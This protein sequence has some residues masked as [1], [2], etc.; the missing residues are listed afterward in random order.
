MS[1]VFRKPSDEN[2]H[3]LKLAYQFFKVLMANEVSMVGG[4]TFDGTDSLLQLI[5]ENEAPL[6]GISVLLVGDLFQLQP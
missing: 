6:G 4:E 2:L 3:K 1:T 5:T